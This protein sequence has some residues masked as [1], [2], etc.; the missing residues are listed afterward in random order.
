MKIIPN[1]NDIDPNEGGSFENLPVNGY[2]CVITKVTDKPDKE[3]LEIEY[4]VAE[5][6]YSGWWSKTAE[7]AGF[8]G[9][10]LI[11]S[12]KDTAA[13]FFKGFTAAVE[14]SNPGY[15][16]DWNE[17]SLVG[18]AIGLVIALEEYRKQDGTYK[19]RLY[20]ARNASVDKIRKGDFTVPQY[21]PV[22]NKPAA[23][24]TTSGFS[25]V[26]DGSEIPFA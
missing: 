25:E 5:G 20:V 11:R 12:Y 22:A 13:G 26:D 23:Q 4:D 8:W 15:K 18:K 19:D 21:K 24:S 2:V 3:Y 16:W 7:R 17:Q 10:K 9:G 1:Y 14:Q 6:K